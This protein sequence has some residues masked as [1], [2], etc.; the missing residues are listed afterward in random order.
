M[1]LRQQ[2][3]EKFPFQIKMADGENTKCIH[4]IESLSRAHVY[5]VDRNDIPHVLPPLTMTGL[6][7]LP[8]KTAERNP[9]AWE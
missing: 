8:Q 2:C 3:R 5:F 6:T 7:Y 9:K 1:L 4:A